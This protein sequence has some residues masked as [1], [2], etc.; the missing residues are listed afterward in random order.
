MRQVKSLVN[1]N[2]LLTK[3]NI[4]TVHYEGKGY[5]TIYDDR[6]VSCA[7]SESRFEAIH[8][9][10]GSPDFSEMQHIADGV[11]VTLQP[12]ESGIKCPVVEQY[13]SRPVDVD[14]VMAELE[15]D[16]ADGTLAQKV[17]GGKISMAEAL[18]HGLSHKP[19]PKLAPDEWHAI[20]PD[21][22]DL[23]D[24][25]ITKVPWGGGSNMTST[26]VVGRTD[27]LKAKIAELEAQVKQLTEASKP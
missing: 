4:Y 12:D 5:L 11:K 1:L 23:T 22:R 24:G 19:D 7:Y 2:G 13:K 26:F 27:L 8:T 21:Y 17:H 18:I 3:G 20:F 25:R 16:R 9:P 10:K 14:T 15:K 6:G